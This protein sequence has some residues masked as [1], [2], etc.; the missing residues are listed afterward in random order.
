MTKQI[1]L[2]LSL[3]FIILLIAGTGCVTPP[4]GSTPSTGSVGEVGTA[5]PTETVTTETPSYVTAA[6]P[7]VTETPD[8][9]TGAS[10][11]NLLVPTSTLPPEDRSCLIYSNT[12]NFI[13]NTSAINF[14]L[15]NPP[16]YINYTVIP[17]NVTVNKWVQE[18]T[19]SK[20]EVTYT[21]SDYAPYSWFEITVRNKTS[22]EVYLDDGFGSAKGLSTY[23][24]A[25][26]KVMKSDDMLIE[27]KGQSI[28]AT[29]GIWVKPVGNF[30]D[31]YNRTFT[32]CKYWT[33]TQNSL[34]IVTA[35]T[36]PTWTPENQV[37]GRP[38]S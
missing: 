10:G 21:Y 38:S 8:N 4:K 6:T 1:C 18:R 25:T 9:G 36:T 13:Y 35:T 23:T 26:L 12:Q 32:E 30:D 5:G 27:F 28:T 16:M 19:G 24:S 2:L 17:T 14:N 20:K 37:Q 3:L 31:P 15:K 11:A 22:G 34:P 33:Q 29:V 7:F